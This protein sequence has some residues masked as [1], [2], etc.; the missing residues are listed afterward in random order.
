MHYCCQYHFQF[1]ND[2]EKDPEYSRFS[3][4]VYDVSNTIIHTHMY[5]YTDMC[6]CTWTVH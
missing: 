2:L 1:I 5:M 3:S 6:T 4:S